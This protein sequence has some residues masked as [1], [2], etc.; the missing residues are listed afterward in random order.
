[1]SPLA[2][3]AHPS[4][5]LYGADRVFAESVA[6][7]TGAGWRVVATLPQDGPLTGLLTEHGARVVLCPT[8][9]LRKAALRPAGFARLLADAVRSVPPM[10][11]LLRTERP[12]VVY[13]NT[14]TMPAWLLLAR[15]TRRRVLAHVHEAEDAVPAPVRIGL[16]APLLAADSVVVNSEATGAVLAGTLPRLSGRTRLV[17]NGVPGPGSPP[18]RR[19][20]AGDPIRLVLVGRVSPRKGTDTAVEAVLALNRAGRKAVLDVVGSVFPGY[21]WFEDELRARISA[22]GLAGSV[23][24]NGFRTDVWDAYHDA[25]IAVVPSRVEPFGNTSVEAQLAGVPVV[26]TDAQGL[27]ETVQNGQCGSVVPA[28][29]PAALAEAITALVDDW[30]AAIERARAAK[31][32]AERDFAPE[33]YRGEIVAMM[34]EL[35]KRPGR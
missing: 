21:E 6:A 13:V 19:A 3:M 14:V 11:R 33:R 22:A 23:R 7:L 34:T 15:L 31:E 30:P 12:S 35:S 24:L 8:P 20:S 1:M 9:V 32:R 4:S 26:V 27:P 28:D 18:R 25:D 16:A 17:Y 2:L 10:L 5:G 29:D